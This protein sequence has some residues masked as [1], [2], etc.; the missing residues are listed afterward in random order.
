MP[1]RP[2]PASSRP[3]F[4]HPSGSP[5][6]PRCA[7]PPAVRRIPC[8]VKVL[9][10]RPRIG[11]MMRMGIMA[12]PDGSDAGILRVRSCSPR[13]IG[14]GP[15]WSLW[16]DGVG[17]RGWGGGGPCRRP[18]P[19]RAPTVGRR[20]SPHPLGV[21]TRTASDALPERQGSGVRRRHGCVSRAAGVHGAVADAHPPHTLRESTWVQRTP[22]SNAAAPVR[23]SWASARRRDSRRPRRAPR[24]RV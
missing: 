1:S 4:S 19:C 3:T 17:R 6:R 7:P 2:K 14:R 9:A 5:T 10:R 12:W 11:V 15:V 20:C 8:I 21:R 16:G 22:C 13:R 23:P 24:A 18:C